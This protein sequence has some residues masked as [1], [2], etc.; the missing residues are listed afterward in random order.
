[1]SISKEVAVTAQ[2]QRLSNHNE[3]A[4][5]ELGTP[6]DNA[7]YV[8]VRLG[9]NQNWVNMRPGQSV[10]LDSIDLYNVE[11]KGEVGDVIHFM[12]GNW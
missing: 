9:A 10:R 5:G 7:A 6:D 2:A 1:M 4:S 12:G 11:F 8:Q 3:T